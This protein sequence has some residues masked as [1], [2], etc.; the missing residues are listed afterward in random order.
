MPG[1]SLYILI[2]AVILAA[3]F[4]AAR[5]DH[6][7]APAAPIGEF[8][9][10]VA[11]YPDSLLA[12][13]Q[14]MDSRGMDSS[15]HVYTTVLRSGATGDP[16]RAQEVLEILRKSMERYK[17]SRVAV[18]DGFQPFLPKTDQ[19]LYWFISAHNAYLAAYEFNPGHPT[20]LLY[21]KA[22]GNYEL[23]GALFTAP[24]AATE[25]QLNDRVPLSI[26]R[27]HEHVNL[28][29]SP[30]RETNHPGD[31]PKF[32]LAGSIATKDACT[33]AGGRWVPQVFGWMVAVFPFESQPS[34]IWPQ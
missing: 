19:H 21:K 22:K 26:A 5:P 1:R 20:A 2:L 13:A 27:W 12:A 34:A 17:D 16:Q 29:V 28:C 6:R 7:N 9:R 3:P 18:A 32:G 11:L 31:A 33:A 30:K 8:E 23:Q 4:A 15:P 25:S 10:D 14:S 24:K